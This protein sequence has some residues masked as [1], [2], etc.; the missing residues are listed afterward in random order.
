M[1]LLAGSYKRPLFVD[2]QVGSL[3]LLLAVM[4]AALIVA[5]NLSSFSFFSKGVQRSLS[6]FSYHKGETLYC[7]TDPNDWELQSLPYR[8]RVPSNSGTLFA[9]CL[10]A[11]MDYA[12]PGQKRH[13]IPAICALS[14][15][16]KQP[17]ALSWVATCD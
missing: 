16:L 6:L 5:G 4:I 12:A 13:T 11:R 14:H 15:Y 9:A 17:L 7:Q 2:R 8:L 3:A 10:P 1:N